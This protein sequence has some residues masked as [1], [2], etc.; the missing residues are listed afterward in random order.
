VARPASPLDASLLG[1][2]NRWYADALRT[3][4]SVELPIGL[5]LKAIT[6]PYFLGTKIEASRGRGHEDYFGSHDLEDFNTVIDGRPSLLQEVG[7]ASPDLRV[8]CG[9]TARASLHV[10]VP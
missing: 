2:Y 8:P 10:T 6:T 1:F 7:E 3:A 9:G 5:K 4:V